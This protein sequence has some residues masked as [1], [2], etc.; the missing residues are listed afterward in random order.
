MS[1]ELPNRT[2]H[3]K[4]NPLKLKSFSCGAICTSVYH[5][6]YRCPTYD[7]VV[8]WSELLVLLL[9]RDHFSTTHTTFETFTRTVT[10]N[11]ALCYRMN[12]L[13]SSDFFKLN[14]VILFSILHSPFSILHS[15]FSILHSP[16][17]I[18]HRKAIICYNCAINFLGRT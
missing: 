6:T 3:P 5:L 12:F 9:L 15:P 11:D 13:R 16:F 1:Q 14:S 4:Q 10:F 2:V 7:L 17:S 8:R 18:L